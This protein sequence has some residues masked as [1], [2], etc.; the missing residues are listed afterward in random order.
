MILTRDRTTLFGL[1]FSVCVGVGGGAY[2]RVFVLALGNYAWLLLP[3]LLTEEM[4]FHIREIAGKFL[5]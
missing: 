2:A 1:D 3:L 4:D 5:Q